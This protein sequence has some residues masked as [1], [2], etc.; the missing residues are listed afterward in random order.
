MN[1]G[2]FEVYS[3]GGK[4][5]NKFKALSNEWAGVDYFFDDKNNEWVIQEIES[6]KQG[7]G[8]K[9][10]KEFTNRIGKDQKVKVIAI[11][12]PDSRQR[13]EDLGILDFV[14]KNKQAVEITTPG[15]FKS[16]KMTRLLSGGGLNVDKIVVSPAGPEIKEDLEIDLKYQKV[17]IEI[18]CHT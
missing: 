15:V 13:L 11:I 1:E 5:D 9:V 16:F 10:I 17:S 3:Y 14:E 7:E 12:E 2:D 6:K 8:K 18:N 4:G